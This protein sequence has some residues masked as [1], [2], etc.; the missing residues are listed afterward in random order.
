MSTSNVD[1]HSTDEDSV[2][3]A[4]WRVNPWCRI[5]GNMSR[6]KFYEERKAGRIDTVKMGSATLVVTSPKQYVA[7]LRLKPAQV[8]DGITVGSAPALDRVRHVQRK[9]VLPSEHRR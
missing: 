9:A 1:L 7:S 2:E 3:P 6:S 5:V 4:A 8:Q